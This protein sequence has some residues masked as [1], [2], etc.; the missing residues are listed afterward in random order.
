M[1]HSYEEI[2][3]VKAQAALGQMLRYAVEDLQMG[4]NEFWDMFLISG[5]ADLFGKGDYRF[6]V[7]MSGV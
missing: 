3:T 7:G 6:L 1:M 2:Y 4:L 5:I